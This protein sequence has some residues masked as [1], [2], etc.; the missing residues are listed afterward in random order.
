MQMIHKAAVIGILVV[1]SG[2]DSMD[3]KTLFGCMGTFIGI[4]CWTAPWDIAERT[5]EDEGGKNS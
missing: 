4:A 5:E 1:M 3:L 2:A